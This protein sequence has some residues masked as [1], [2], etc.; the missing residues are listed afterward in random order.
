MPINLLCSIIISFFSGIFLVILLRKISL[1]YNLLI[2][3]GIPLIGGISICLSFLIGCLYANNFYV[4]LNKD[5][6][7]ILFASFLML[8]FGIIDDFHELSIS[9]KFISQFI[10]ASFLIFFGVKTQIIYFSA[11]INII[12]TYIWIIG[13]T[14]AFNHLDILDGL[15][16]GN[17]IIICVAFYILSILNINITTLIL[18]LCLTAATLAFFIFNFPPAKIYMGNSGSHFLGFVLSAIALK[19]SYASLNNS[20]A[21]FSPLVILGFP[22][23]DTAFL[24]LIRSSKNILPFKKSNDHLALRFLTFNYSKR[25]TLL[26][27][28][29]WCLFF[30]IS[31][32]I[33]TKIS[34]LQAAI[35]IIIVILLSIFLANKML[36]TNLNA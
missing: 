18:S 36:K 4:P 11:P 22:I 17:A 8:V 2:S 3:K 34:N 15:T 20:I 16:A 10:A 23:I 6:L 14:N 19:I 30:S 21:I 13:I 25:K 27:M 7:G 32:V 12:I 35:L 33:I 1:K 9:V 5:I 26:I 29:G 24:I 31:G 28:L